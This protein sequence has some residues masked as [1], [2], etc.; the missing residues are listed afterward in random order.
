[1]GVRYK[2]FGWNPC[3]TH[4]LHRGT[5]PRVPRNLRPHPRGSC[6]PSRLRSRPAPQDE[7]ETTQLLN[8]WKITS[9]FTSNMGLPPNQCFVWF[10]HVFP[11]SPLKL[12]YSEWFLGVIRSQ[13]GLSL[14]LIGAS[15]GRSL[16]DR[17]GHQKF[18][19]PLFLVP[20]FRIFIGI[21]KLRL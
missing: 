14:D 10:F 7:C 18:P 2:I 1:M 17:Q 12:P 21:K 6:Q 8:N 20:D 19:N 11:V 4:H 5:P 3:R 16:A 9:I 15:L 13:P